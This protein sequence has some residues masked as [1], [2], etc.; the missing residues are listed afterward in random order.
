MVFLVI[1]WFWYKKDKNVNG[2]LNYVIIPIQKRQECKWFSLLF[3]NSDTKKT[4]ME[5]VFFVISWFWYKKDKNVN[6]F[7]RYFLIMIK[8]RQEYKLVSF[9]FHDFQVTHALVWRDWFLKFFWAFTIIDSRILYRILNQRIK[10]DF[11]A[12]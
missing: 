4:K 11:N 12:L 8:K 9:V 5:M 1:S 10:I 3:H 7:L 6:G 2:C